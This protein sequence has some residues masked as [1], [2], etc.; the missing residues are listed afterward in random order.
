MSQPSY[1]L[2]SSLKDSITSPSPIFQQFVW[3][4]FTEPNVWIRGESD[5]G[6]V[7]RLEGQ[8]RTA[9]IE[10]IATNVR[11]GREHIIRAAVHLKLV[12]VVP[13]LE[14]LLARETNGYGRYILGS[15]LHGLGA[16][17]D[18]ALFDLMSIVMQHG[19]W[20]ETLNVLNH[21]YRAFRPE[22]ARKLID[23]GLH[24]ADFGIR[25]SALNALIAVSYIE[26]HGGHF[27]TAAS[28]VGSGVPRR[29]DEA[30]YF[31]G[32]AVYVD[33]QLFA[34]RLE[35]LARKYASPA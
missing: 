10:M 14:E 21:S 4:F 19:P 22:V 16:L 6:L 5:P 12:R 11:T 17:E 27:T 33:A 1:G 15:A 13:T 34:A 29:Y 31:L 23:I 18:G 8:E 3:Q 35:E 9:A 30:Q 25:F 20:N 26:R 7:E 32:E 28:T 2:D 24:R